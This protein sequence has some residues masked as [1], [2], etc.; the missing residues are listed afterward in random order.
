ME[1]PGSS[2]QSKAVSHLSSHWE[3]KLSAMPRPLL[4]TSQ[5][6]APIMSLLFHIVTLTSIAVKF[7]NAFSIGLNLGIV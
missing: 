7:G 1:I 3:V 4:G 2:E 5:T 6:V